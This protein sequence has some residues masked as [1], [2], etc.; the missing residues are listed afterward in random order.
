MILVGID[1][2]ISYGHIPQINHQL[3]FLAIAVSRVDHFSKGIEVVGFFAGIF[4]QFDQVVN[5]SILD[6]QSLTQ[7]AA[8]SLPLRSPRML[9]PLEPLPS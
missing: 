5:R 4:R 7:A 2:L 9:D 6:L 1:A 8:A 3:L